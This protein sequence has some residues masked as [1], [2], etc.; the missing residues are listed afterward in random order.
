M[1]LATGLYMGFNSDSTL[2]TGYLAVE[3]RTIDGEQKSVRTFLD[4]AINADK[5]GELTQDDINNIYISSEAELAL[6]DKHNKLLFPVETDKRVEV[7]NLKL[8]QQEDDRTNYINT[9][10]YTHLRAHE[11]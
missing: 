1:L 6:N 4:G 7:P 11:T 5:W 9:V 10:S 2:F 8:K 3:D